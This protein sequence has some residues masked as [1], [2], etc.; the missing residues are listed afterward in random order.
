LDGGK[1]FLGVS[2]INA[3]HNFIQ[4]HVDRGLIVLG[5]VFLQR[6]GRLVLF[7][8][9]ALKELIILLVLAQLDG[10]VDAALTKFLEFSGNQRLFGNF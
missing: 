3:R 1:F 7:Y 2:A 9:T 8:V 5:I 4:S 6:E 10:G